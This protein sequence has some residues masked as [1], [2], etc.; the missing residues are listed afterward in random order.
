MRINREE[1]D[2]EGVT[3]EGGRDSFQKAP[4]RE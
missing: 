4:E 2:R 1:K 3:G